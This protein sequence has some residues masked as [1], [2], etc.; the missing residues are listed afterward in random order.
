MIVRAVGLGTPER[1]P[2]RNKPL[3]CGDKTH[4]HDSGQ[5]NANASVRQRKGEKQNDQNKFSPMAAEGM[6]L[7]VGQMPPYKGR[8]SDQPMS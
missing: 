2:I 3:A 7:A 4:P 5:R 6:I 1:C 8:E